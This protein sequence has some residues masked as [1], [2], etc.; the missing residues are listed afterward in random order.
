MSAVYAQF[1]EHTRNVGA[2]L[3][4]GFER[5]QSMHLKYAHKMSIQT[6]K[7]EVCFMFVCALYMAHIYSNTYIFELKACFG[8]AV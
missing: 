6:T 1:R 2:S 3:V 5:I 4:H 8:P 7:Q